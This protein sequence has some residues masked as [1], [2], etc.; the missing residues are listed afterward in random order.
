MITTRTN[1]GSLGIL[2]VARLEIT[3][4]LF[5]D[6]VRD[7]VL[8]RTVHLVSPFGLPKKLRAAHGGG[9]VSRSFNTDAQARRVAAQLL[10]AWAAAWGVPVD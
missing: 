9:G 1:G 6:I 8:S 5:V 10:M 7:G 4:S 3:D 2:T